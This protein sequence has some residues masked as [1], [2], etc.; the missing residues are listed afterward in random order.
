M[1]YIQVIRAAAGSIV[2]AAKMEA[3]TSAGS[4][5]PGAGGAN[6]AARGAGLQAPGGRLGPGGRQREESKGEVGAPAPTRARAREGG[7]RGR[8]KNGGG[9]RGARPGLIRHRR[10]G[11]GRLREGAAAAAGGAATPAGGASEEVALDGGAVCGGVRR[12]FRGPAR[13]AGRLRALTRR[14][15]SCGRGEADGD[16]GGP[17]GDGRVSQPGTLPFGLPGPHTELSRESSSTGGACSR[18]QPHIPTTHPST[19][20]PIPTKPTTPNT[21]RGLRRPGTGPQAQP[22]AAV[23]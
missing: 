19:A 16:G 11:P 9:R 23:G 3:G 20:T 15:C 13:A 12:A 2:L 5:W 17:G 18:G 1:S 4:R 7:A 8:Q 10:R 6:G 21:R 14:C 22:P